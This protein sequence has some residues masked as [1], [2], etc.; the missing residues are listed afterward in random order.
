MAT[1][2]AVGVATSFYSTDIALEVDGLHLMR[3]Q[4]TPSHL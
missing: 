2:L 4:T 3:N 1:L